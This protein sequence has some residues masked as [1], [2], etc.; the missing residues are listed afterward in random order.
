MP[1]QHQESSNARN[2]AIGRLTSFRVNREPIRF[3]YNRIFNYIISQGRTCASAK[4]GIMA[5]IMGCTAAHL[6]PGAYSFAGW[7]AY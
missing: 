5:R 6:H 4:L 3:G 7:L 1:L 2:V